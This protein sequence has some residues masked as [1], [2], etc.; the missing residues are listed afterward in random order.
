[1]DAQPQRDQN[2]RGAVTFRIRNG[3]VYRRRIVNGH[4]VWQD[5]L[6]RYFS[7]PE[8]HTPGQSPERPP[9]RYD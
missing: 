8:P 4:V 5:A 3:V 7:I 9:R 2:R 6:G 1:M